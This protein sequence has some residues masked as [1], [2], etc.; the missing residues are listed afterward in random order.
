MMLLC[1][2]GNTRVK[3][4]LASARGRLREGGAVEHEGRWNAAALERSLPRLAA[5]ERVVACSVAPAA[6]DA[7]LEAWLRR[8]WSVATEWM[9]AR[10][11]GWGV[12]CAYAAPETMGADRW[13]MLV[14]ARRR[15]PG[16]AC[17]AGCGT[18]VTVDLL[19]EGAGTSAA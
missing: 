11:Q 1:D 3:W 4:A 8:R 10:R 13:A 9:P 2:I 17:V 7:G 6:L 14:A 18:A 5:V 12:R 19:D 16:G 15:S